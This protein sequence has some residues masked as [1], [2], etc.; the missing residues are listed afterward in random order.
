MEMIFLTRHRLLTRTLGKY[1]VKKK[2][3]TFEKKNKKS[4]RK[5]K[6]RQTCCLNSLSPFPE[7]TELYSLD[8]FALKFFSMLEK[9]NFDIIQEPEKFLFLSCGSA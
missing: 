2:K 5:L 3:K 7:T 4:S 8:L 1:P 6:S 9:Y